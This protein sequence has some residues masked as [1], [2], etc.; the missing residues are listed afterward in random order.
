MRGFEVTG[1]EARTL[2][3]ICKRI[4][5]GEEVEEYQCCMAAKRKRP[6]VYAIGLFL[7]PAM[8]DLSYM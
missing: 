8:P 1:L 7:L 2:L 4:A 6:M 3:R 5:R